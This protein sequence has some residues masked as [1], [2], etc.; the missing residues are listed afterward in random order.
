MLNYYC[1]Y[2]CCLYIIDHTN[3]SIVSIRH[4][5]LCNDVA[6][7]RVQCNIAL[8]CGGVV[9]IIYSRLSSLSLL[10]A[11]SLL[12]HTHKHVR[13]MLC[14]YIYIYVVPF[15]RSIGEW[16]WSDNDDNVRWCW[17]C[18]TMPSRNACQRS[19]ALGHMANGFHNLPT[20]W[21]SLQCTVHILRKWHVATCSIW[22]VVVATQCHFTSHH[23]WIDSRVNNIVRIYSI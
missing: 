2:V 7:K 3:K 9:H 11:N 20:V 23:P 22:S 8:Y 6:R 17:R 4:T 12:L 19:N 14:T 18:S 16:A 10:L 15:G 13:A 5:T 21:R 1:V